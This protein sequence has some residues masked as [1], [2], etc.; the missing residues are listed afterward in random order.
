MDHDD[1]DDDRRNVDSQTELGRTPRSTFLSI[2]DRVVNGPTPSAPLGHRYSDNI[3]IPG[4]KQLVHYFRIPTIFRFHNLYP[5]FNLFCRMLGLYCILTHYCS[6]SIS[7]LNHHVPLISMC[8]TE[9]LA[10]RLTLSRSAGTVLQ[11]MIHVG[12]CLDDKDS[13][14]YP[15]GSPL[16]PQRLSHASR[17][18]R[19]D[20]FLSPHCIALLMI[21]ISAAPRHFFCVT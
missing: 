9:Y 1:D 12:R 20:E 8:I 5:L 16:L 7:P 3:L 11:I 19:V 17:R 18:R 21:I 14:D 4:G 13:R 10:F 2:S 6:L 15:L